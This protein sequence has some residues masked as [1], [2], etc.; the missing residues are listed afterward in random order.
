M[1]KLLQRASDLFSRFEKGDLP[2]VTLLRGEEAYLD[3]EFKKILE[4]KNFEWNEV[5][6]KK[7]APEET[8]ED[9]GSGLSLFS[10]QN[11]LWIRNPLSPA[12]WRSDTRALWKR[13]RE[14]CDGQTNFIIAQVPADKR[15]KWDALECDAE[16]TWEVEPAQKRFWL[17]RMNHVRQNPLADSE[18]AFLAQFDEEAIVLDNWV[19]LWA[20]GGSTWASK[21]LGWGASVPKNTDVVSAQP[22]FAWV[23]AVLAGDRRHSQKLLHKLVRED[24]TEPLQLLA[25]LGK[26]V[27]ILVALENG[28]S[29]DGQPAF[30]VDKLR[31]KKGRGTRLLQL[32]TQI[33]RELKSTG[34]DKYALML[35]L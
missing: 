33:D 24:S 5:D 28:W 8:L 15:L 4:R 17:G 25:L 1:A 20:L 23:D 7:R 12:Q 32:C 6:L 10:N 29:L 3:R 27:R 26:S 35:R 21:A 14:R 22:A 18:L 30:L 34:A 16:F 13:M 19:E 11:L 9:F 2:P 31:S